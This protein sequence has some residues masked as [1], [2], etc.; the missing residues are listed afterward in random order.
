M[1]EL[2]QCIENGDSN[3]AGDIIDSGRVDLNERY[4]FGRSALHLCLNHNRIEIAE[5]LIMNGCD[6]NAR[7]MYGYTTLN[8]SVYANNLQ[9]AKLLIANGCHLNIG[10]NNGYT[11]L[12]SCV[13]INKPVFAELLIMSGCNM[14]VRDLTGNTALDHAIIADN[15]TT[16][17]LTMQRTPL[18]IAAGSDNIVRAEELV[19]EGCD[20]NEISAHGMTAMHAAAKYGG[21]ACAELLIFNGARLDIAD[22]SG[23]TALDYPNTREDIQSMK[24]MRAQR[25]MAYATGTA[26]PRTRPDALPNRSLL[27]H[28]PVELRAKIASH[29]NLLG[30]GDRAI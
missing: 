8:R 20:I 23:R 19:D 10:N 27:Q 22:D 13:F 21:L 11:A 1:A 7:D 3:A 24:D 9:M 16:A 29:A 17:V 26:G 18:L 5:M 2:I 4:R 14:G 25:R 28:V 6:I 15:D 12:H 30:Y